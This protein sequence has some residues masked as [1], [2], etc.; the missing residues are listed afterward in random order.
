M[1]RHD[2][3]DAEPGEGLKVSLTSGPIFIIAIALMVLQAQAVFVNIGG[4][5]LSVYALVAVSGLLAVSAAARLIPALLGNQSIGSRRAALR[6]LGTMS[7]LVILSSYATLRLALEW[8]LEG[9]QNLLALYVLT[10]GPLVFWLSRSWPTPEQL[11]RMMSWV[12]GITAIVYI[13]FRL[14][15]LPGFADRQFAMVALVGLATSVGL[16][17]RGFLEKLIPY[18]VLIGITASGS[19]TA[20]VIALVLFSTLALR[21]AGSALGKVLYV[22]ALLGVGVGVAAL[23]FVILGF[24]SERVEESGVSGTVAEVILNSN[25]R[26]GAWAEFLNLLTSPSDWFFGRGTGAAMEFGT[27][28]LAFFSHPHNEYIRYLVDLGI[29]GLLLLAAGC[30]SMLIVLLKDQGF[31]KDAPRAATLVIIALAGMS[32]T[33]G[34][35]YSSFVIIPAALVVGAGLRSTPEHPVLSRKVHP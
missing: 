5:S 26:F 19:R 16:T 4:L 20:S 21:Y 15:E 34:P 1:P 13:I 9:A 24:I 29:V 14:A 33:D 32:L 31:S 22:F 11:L 25:G 23:S 35:L 18:I 27:A 8:R 12:T 3:G 28:N 17:P 6:A 7:P 10:L 30:I 2:I